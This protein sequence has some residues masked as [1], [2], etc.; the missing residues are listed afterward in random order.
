MS[1]HPIQRIRSALLLDVKSI[2]ASN[3]VFSQIEE[4]F[5]VDGD[6]GLISISNDNFFNAFL[7]FRWRQLQL[8]VMD[9]A[10]GLKLVFLDHALAKKGL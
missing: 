4:F 9:L 2:T 6:V 5:C 7:R 3:P 1:E 10:G 8:L